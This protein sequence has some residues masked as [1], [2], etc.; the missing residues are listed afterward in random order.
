MKIRHAL[1]RHS[2]PRLTPPFRAPKPIYP[3]WLVS[4]NFPS[5]QGKDTIG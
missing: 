3:P 1:A 5:P 4:K 2:S